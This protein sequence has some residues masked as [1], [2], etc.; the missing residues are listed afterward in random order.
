MNTENLRT[1]IRIQ[2]DT[3]NSAFTDG[4]EPSQYT[5]GPE[6]ARILREIAD[7][8]EWDDAT[9]PLPLLDYNGNRVGVYEH[10][11]VPLR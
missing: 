1:S 5:P 4:Q 11:A 8:I 2:I 10:H 6:I 3:G 7:R 9:A